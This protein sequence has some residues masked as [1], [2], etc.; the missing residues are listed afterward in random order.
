[1]LLPIGKLRKSRRIRAEG[2]R[3]ELVAGERPPKN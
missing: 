1:V 3:Q 2:E